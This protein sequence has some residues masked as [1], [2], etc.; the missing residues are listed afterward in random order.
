[1]F[2]RFTDR[3]RRVVVQ[4]QEEARQLHHSYIGTEHLLLALLREQEGIGPGALQALGIRHGDALALV[5]QVIGRGEKSPIGHIPFTPR[6]KKV[7]ELSLRE[8]IQLG[9]G[10]I[11]AVHILLGILRDGEGVANNVLTQMGASAAAIRVKV[12]ELMKVEPA[13]L[14]RP[15]PRQGRA[16]RCK[17]PDESLQIIAAKGM[18]TV[19]CSRCGELVGVLP[20][21]PEEAS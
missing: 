19:R 4:A 3:A 17:H 7:L 10:D 9:S 13:E 21:A 8:S 12:A 11:G 20:E 15:M 5:E 2:E 14:A 18:R 6:A 1:V 16:F